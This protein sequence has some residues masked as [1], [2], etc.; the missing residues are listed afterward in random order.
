MLTIF[1]PCQPV[2]PAFL[3]AD[4]LDLAVFCDQ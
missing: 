2:H 1:L 3:H 4:E